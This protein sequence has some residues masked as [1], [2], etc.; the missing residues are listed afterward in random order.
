MKANGNRKRLQ[1]NL[2]TWTG[3]ET[4]TVNSKWNKRDIR[5]RSNVYMYTRGEVG[6]QITW[7]YHVLHKGTEDTITIT[8]GFTS[9]S[10]L[11]E[12]ITGWKPNKSALQKETKGND[13]TDRKSATS[14]WRPWKSLV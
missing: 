2:N 6:K 13:F 4:G 3:T 1:R 8:K 14:K 9:Q 11:W 10:E 12:A 7:I 5:T